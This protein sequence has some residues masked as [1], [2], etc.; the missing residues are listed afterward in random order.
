M[1]HDFM[2]NACWVFLDRFYIV[3][4]FCYVDKCGQ[5]LYYNIW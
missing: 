3:N 1:S 2:T 5:L 4:R